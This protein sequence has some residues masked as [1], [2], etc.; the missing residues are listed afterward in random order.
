[1]LLGNLRGIGVHV[2]RVDS[3]DA[4]TEDAITELVPADEGTCRGDPA[5][6]PRPLHPGSVRQQVSLFLFSYGRL[7]LT[8]C[9]VYRRLWH[10]C[11]DAARRAVAWDIE[12]EGLVDQKI[13]AFAIFQMEKHWGELEEDGRA[14]FLPSGIK[15][16]E[17][18]YEFTCVVTD[19]PGEDQVRLL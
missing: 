18:R 2:S 14:L 17:M 11:A 1:M 8:S 16:R 13:H 12:H 7:V 10:V 5:G 9:F 4:A 3:P 15:G 19:S 6:F